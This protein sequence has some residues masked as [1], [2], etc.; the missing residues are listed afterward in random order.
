MKLKYYLRGLGIGIAVTAIVLTIANAG[1]QKPLTD[2]QIMERAEELGMIRPE[3]QKVKDGSDGHTIDNLSG[4]Q[5]DKEEDP[6]K[7]ENKDNPQSSDDKKT[8][9]DK[10][11]SK[12]QEEGGDSE[13]SKPQKEGEDQASSKEQEEPEEQASAKNT[14]E[15]NTPSSDGQASGNGQASQENKT[16]SDDSQTGDGQAPKD[17]KTEEPKDGTKDTAS[18]D[19]DQASQSQQG[20]QKENDQTQST[21]YVTIEI[22]Q[23]DFSDRVSQKLKDAGLVKDASDFNNYLVSNG[24]DGR[25]TIGSH[26]IPQGADYDQIAKILCERSGSS[27]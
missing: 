3:E 14:G 23:G 25:L 16:S 13:A 24:I 15:G 12:K 9:S 10:D 6:S 27:Q 22:S 17:G 1:S 20:S 2:E 8:E 19:E 4:S 11:S 7:E 21:E 18:G 26:Q 5:Q